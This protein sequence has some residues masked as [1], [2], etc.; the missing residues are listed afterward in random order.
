MAR[1]AALSGAGNLSHAVTTWDSSGLDE[2]EICESLCESSCG[3]PLLS[4]GFC[5]VRI[6][7]SPPYSQG[8]SE[9]GTQLGTQT[10]VAACP[11]LAQVVSAR[12]K[13]SA[14]LK[15]A[16]LAIVN[17]AKGDGK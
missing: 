16:I 10:K 7:L 15:A 4:A 13:L 9:A 3:F 14:P 2:T 17:S 11:Q 8:N 5:G 1:I 6:P 12:A